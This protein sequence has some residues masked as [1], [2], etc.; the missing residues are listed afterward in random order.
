MSL[1]FSIVRT[2]LWRLLASARDTRSEMGL[3]ES[4]S[5]WVWHI[6]RERERGREGGTEGVGRVGGGRERERERAGC[7][8]PSPPSSHSCGGC[9]SLHATHAVSW[10]IRED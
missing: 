5:G 8:W 3:E 1:A 2:Q 6:E 10:S 9:W 7:P 4:K